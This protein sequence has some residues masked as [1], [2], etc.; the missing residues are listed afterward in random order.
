M[1]ELLQQI[2][3][4]AYVAILTALITAAVTLLGVLFTNLGNTARI[5]LQLE[6]ERSLK[7]EELYRER[8]EELYVLFETWSTSLFIYYLPYISV[9]EGKISYNDA[10]DQTIKQ[11]SESSAD[12]HRLQMLVDIYFPEVKPEFNALLEYRSKTNDI[13]SK[14]KLEYKNGNIDGHKF[15]KP[16]LASQNEIDAQA[17]EVKEKII[18]QVK[19]V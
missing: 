4:T 17:Q 14:H 8:L 10:L 2:P 11:G 7:K 1:I 19:K 5:R 15:L 13:L 12:F 16:F 18:E 6:H 9:M 3:A